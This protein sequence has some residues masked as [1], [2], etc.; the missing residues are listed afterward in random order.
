MVSNAET[1]EITNVVNNEDKFEMF[2]SSQSSSVYSDIDNTINNDIK[3][4][5]NGFKN[6]KCDPYVSKVMEYWKMEK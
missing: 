6:I 4:L 3:I 5:L 1:S 2:L